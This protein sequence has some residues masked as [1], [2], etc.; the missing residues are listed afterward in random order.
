MKKIVIALV[1]TCCSLQLSAQENPVAPS[2]STLKVNPTTLINELDLYWEQELSNKF[3]LEFGAT[4]IY[5]DYPDYLL[6]KRIDIGQKKPD[7]STDQFVEG[8]GFGARVGF[9]WYLFALNG[10]QHASGTYFQPSLLYKRVYYP[11][12]DFDFNDEVFKNKAH[13]DVYGLQFL[14]GRQF[15]RQKVVFDPYLGVGIRGKVYHYA[16]YNVEND[17]LNLDK[18]H[19]VSILPSVHLGIKIGLNL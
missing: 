2:K 18:G 6:S 11:A 16:N 13:K 15:T 4:F 5:S 14:I 12:T 8:L 7:I 10:S 9:R 19:M 3:S 1:I 17:V